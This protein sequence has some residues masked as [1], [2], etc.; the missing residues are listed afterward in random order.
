M[1]IV[2]LAVC[3]FA[4]FTFGMIRKFTPL[5]ALAASLI[6]FGHIVPVAAGTNPFVTIVPG[7]TARSVLLFHS[8]DPTFPLIPETAESDSSTTSVQSTGGA[9]FATAPPPVS[10]TKKHKITAGQVFEYAVPSLMITYGI[11]STESPWL[12]GLDYSTRDELIEDN[13]MLYNRLDNYLQFSPAVAAFTMKIAGVKS[14]HNF[15]QMLVLYA[16]S[17]LVETGV[18]YTM[19][20]TV[21]R[22]RPDGAATNS[23]P[24]GH[25]ATA[26]VAAEFLHQEYKHKSVWISVGGYAMASLIGASRIYNNRHW[27]SDVITGAGIGILS[28]KLVY[29]A[30]RRAFDS[31]CEKRPKTQQALVLPTYSNGMLGAHFSYLF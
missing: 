3:F 17:N 27:I 6:L 12:R 8:A 4:T 28:T 10:Y 30:F 2:G 24:S 16:I 29:L 23:F 5:S 22:L 31:S 14:T 1:R 25:T 19:K 7:D 21:P 26:F 13:S 18:V 11:L 15:R 9:T 20:N